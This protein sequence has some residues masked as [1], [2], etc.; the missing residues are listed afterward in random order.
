MQQGGVQLQQVGEFLNASVR[1]WEW[2]YWHPPFN[3]S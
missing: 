2:T 1:K 3:R